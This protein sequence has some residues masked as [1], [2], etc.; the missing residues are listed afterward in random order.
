MV[1]MVFNLFDKTHFIMCNTL[2]FP[3]GILLCFIDIGAMI[4]QTMLPSNPCYL[5]LSYLK[6]VGRR[7]YKHPD[8]LF[9]H[10]RK[11]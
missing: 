6:Y 3:H 5:S 10:D 2:Y 1:D 9:F 4:K 8:T 7:I 11:L